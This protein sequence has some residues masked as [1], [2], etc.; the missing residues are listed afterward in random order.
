MGMG[1]THLYTAL[2]PQITAWSVDTAACSITPGG[3]VNA[4]EKVHYLWPSRTGRMVYVACSNVSP[5]MEKPQSPQHFLAAYRVDPKSGALTL[6]QP[7][8]ALPYR[9]VH[10]TVDARDEHVI[11]GYPGPD[12][13]TVHRLAGDG[14][15]GEEIIQPAGLDFG[16][17]VHQVRVTPSGNSVIA[18]TRGNNAE[19]GRPEDPGAL[20]VY[21]F[22]KGVLR[23]S[24]SIAPNGGYGFGPRHIDFDPRGRWLYAALER[25]NLLHVYGMNGDMPGAEPLFVRSTLGQPQRPGYQLVGTVH[26]HPNGRHV[27]VANRAHGKVDFEGKSVF[28]GCENSI[29]VFRIDQTSGEPKLIQN[30]WTH[31]QHVRCFSMDPSGRMM[32]AANMTSMTVRDHDGGT[33]EEPSNLAIF[34]IGEDGLLE[35]VSR[36]VVESATERMFWMGMVAT[37]V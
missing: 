12:A 3:S 20:K 26:V 35:F 36:Q 31:G 6:N 16:I 9:P 17:Y 23:N 32:V 4:P 13:L 21:G 14:S 8:V 30:A 22:D 2:G 7:P 11:V 15:L 1:N 18:V 5:R 37:E 10:L 25:Q 24:A 27:Y 28:D 19:A 29:A 34:R 33:H